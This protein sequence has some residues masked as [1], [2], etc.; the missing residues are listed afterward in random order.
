MPRSRKGRPPRYE[1]PA[2]KS[3]CRTHL[4]LVQFHGCRL[5]Q[6][7]NRAVVEVAGRNI[8]VAISVEVGCYRI[9]RTPARRERQGRLKCSVAITQENI[10]ARSDGRNRQ[11]QLAVLVEV[12]NVN[13][14]RTG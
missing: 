9:P 6:N 13:S 2:A 7:G 3:I 11:I 5:K 8:E 4:H 14:D 1:M 10:D 12:S